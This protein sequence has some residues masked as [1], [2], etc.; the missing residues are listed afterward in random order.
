MLVF[1]NSAILPSYTNISFTIIIYIYIACPIDTFK[2]SR[3]NVGCRVCPA[4]SSTSNSTAA[5][6]CMCDIGFY[7]ALD[8]DNNDA[9]T[10]ELLLYKHSGK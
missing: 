3:G 10:G 9:C 4:K 1:H 2:D 8:E 6:Y 5:S 7:R